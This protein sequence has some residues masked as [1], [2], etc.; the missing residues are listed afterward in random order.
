MILHDVLAQ[1]L[2]E[3]QK[4]KLEFVTRRAWQFH[5]GENVQSANNPR[6]QTT[7]L[8]VQQHQCATC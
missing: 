6:Q 1:M 2:F 4:Q 7:P 8:Q 3:E 5:R